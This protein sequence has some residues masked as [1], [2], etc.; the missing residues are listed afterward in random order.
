MYSAPGGNSAGGALK[1]IARDQS[2]RP[3]GEP[4]PLIGNPNL[5][6]IILATRRTTDMPDV[7]MP[8]TGRDPDGA[9]D[10]LCAPPHS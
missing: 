1:E 6:C 8:R 4:L 7:G 10:A 5:S 9:Y 2:R 3:I